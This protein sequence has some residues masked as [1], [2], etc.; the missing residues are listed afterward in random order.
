MLLVRVVGHR[1]RAAG[2]WAP[3]RTPPN[4]PPA[5]HLLDVPALWSQVACT[6]GS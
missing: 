5:V 2:T 3:G 4:R 6:I 1:E